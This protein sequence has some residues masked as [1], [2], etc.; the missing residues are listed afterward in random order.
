MR[1]GPYSSSHIRI[2]SWCSNNIDV[3]KEGKKIRRKNSGSA[4]RPSKALLAKSYSDRQG[5]RWHS[6]V[7]VKRLERGRSGL[8]KLHPIRSGVIKP[9]YHDKNTTKMAFPWQWPRLRGQKLQ[10][11]GS[12]AELTER[13]TVRNHR[14]EVVTQSWGSGGHL[15]L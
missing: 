6:F 1:Y 10:R 11:D 2:T 7:Q 5:Q 15:A 14:G 4:K 12:R 13:G 8:D 9:G 3:F